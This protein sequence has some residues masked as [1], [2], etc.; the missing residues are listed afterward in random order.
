MPGPERIDRAKVEAMLAQETRRFAADHPRSRA[1]FERAQRSLLAGVPMPWMVRWAGGFPIFVAEGRG[2]WFT[3]VDGRD[4]VDLCLGDTGAMTGH[5]PPAVV[6]AAAARLGHGATFML[7]TE[8]T[9]VVAE[10][11]ARRFGLP[12]WQFALTATDANRFAIRLARHLTGRPKILV[13]NWCYHG[14]VDEA[15]ATLDARGRVAARPGNLGPPVDPA[16]T[17]KVVEFNDVASLEAALAPGDV[18]CV[19]AEPALT[20]IGIVLPSPGFHDALRAATRA[21]GTI[22]ILDETH[23]LSAGPGGCTRAWGLQPDILTVGKAIAS[24]VPG[25]VYGLSAALAAAIPPRIRID[26]ADAGGIGGTLAGNA[27]SIAAMRATLEAVLTESVFRETIALA[28]RWADGVEGVI[29]ERRLPWHV[30]RLGC[31]AE[32]WFRDTPPRN[33]G[34]AAASV[35]PLLERTLHL[36]ALNRGVLITPFHNMALVAPGTTAADIDRHTAAF[37]DSV[38]AILA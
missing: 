11:L 36:A 27:L 5:A 13:F 9:I 17:T 33:G 21:T 24:G 34:E 26:E 3:D 6:E 1:L 4:Y 16:V 35:D 32:Y 14:T 19:L 18:A 25:A 15:F 29:R 28:D 8:E 20:N 22:L 37:A 30:N 12:C 23:T 7:P 2:P 31:R 10:E 38:A